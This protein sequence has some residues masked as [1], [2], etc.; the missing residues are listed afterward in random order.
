MRYLLQSLIRSLKVLVGK[1][2]TWDRET[3]WR[4]GSILPSAQTVALGLVE[5]KESSSRIAI[6]VTHDCDLANGIEDEPYVEVIVGTLIRSCLSEKT[7]AKNVRVLHIEINA[8][9]ER[10]NLELVAR[11]K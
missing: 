10:K 1:N 6:V 4:Q 5:K 2:K 7:H 11:E 3:P 9:G 8:L